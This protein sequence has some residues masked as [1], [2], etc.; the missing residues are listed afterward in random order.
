MVSAVNIVS[1]GTY[2]ILDSLLRSASEFAVQNPHW[3][4]VAY[5]HR[6]GMFNYSN[7]EYVEVPWAKRS[8]LYRIYAEYFYF[9]RVSKSLDPK[10]WLSMHDI[11]PSVKADVRAVYCHNPT[12][13]YRLKLSDLRFD[14]KIV[15]F[16]LF[17]KFLYKINI[18][19]NQYVIVQQEW[20]RDAFSTMFGLSD[21]KIVVAF[22]ERDSLRSEQKNMAE[23]DLN[24]ECR[25]FYPSLPRQFKNFEV[26]CR[27]AQIL[28]RQGINNFKVTLT[29]AGTETKYARWVYEK[30]KELKC[31]EFVGLIPYDEMEGRYAETDCLI[32]P[33]FLETWG[34]PI[35]EFMV[36]NRPILTA[37]LPYARETSCGAKLCEYFDPLSGDDLAQKMK[38]VIEGDLT[39]FKPV[40]RHE[41]REP[42]V[43]SWM[44]LCKLLTNDR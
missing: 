6:H 27:A 35:S 32:F 19:R 11:T 43:D 15:L 22:P 40:V 10:V 26:V 42:M 39:D 44:K 17:Y 8:W 36:Y 4:I 30:Y 28:E 3:R 16:T 21:K 5:V 12:P 1:G 14:Y 34:L 2:S 31:V 18:H 29:L 38:K 25:F 41:V 7:I 33:S 37:D 24:K 23:R 20:I 9:K 13:F